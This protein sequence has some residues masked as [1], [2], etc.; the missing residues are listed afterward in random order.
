MSLLRAALS[1]VCCVSRTDGPR[2]NRGAFPSLGLVSVKIRLPN[3]EI[4]NLDISEDTTVATA[5][6]L[7]QRALDIPAEGL[8]LRRNGELL[9]NDQTPFA[10]ARDGKVTFV[11]SRPRPHEAC[12]AWCRFRYT[13]G[14]E[15]A[16]KF[17]QASDA[18]DLAGLVALMRS[19]EPVEEVEEP[20]HPW[21]VDCRTIGALAG[22]HIASA[23]SPPHESCGSPEPGQHP[24][25]KAEVA[26]PPHEGCEAGEKGEAQQ[27][28][29]KPDPFQVKQTVCDLG[30]IPL[31]V[32]FLRSGQEDRAQIAVLALRFLAAEPDGD[33]CAHAAYRAGALPL[34][35]Q[36]LDESEGPQGMAATTAL[37]NIF[38]QTEQYQEEFVQLGGMKGI[39]RQI[40]L[41]P[42]TDVTS[43]LE[44]MLNLQELLEDSEG[45]VLEKYGRLAIELGAL[46]ILAELRDSLELLEEHAA[47]EE[48][49]HPQPQEGPRDA[50]ALICEVI[51]VLENVQRASPSDPGAS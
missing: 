32:D 38:I 4:Y 21:A 20:K 25:E 39:L 6:Q 11:L 24:S 15:D 5:K 41:V 35:V 36:M 9:E 43:I 51:S 16:E 13:A 31:L 2:Q 17:D 19:S 14:G 46:D 27:H 49:V 7:L 1:S 22:S 44:P 23:A 50:H 45:H 48:Q 34:L 3:G 26:S 29:E 12:S 30:A 42:R 10:E 28:A 18:N 8:R 47:A 40:R 37:R 33:A